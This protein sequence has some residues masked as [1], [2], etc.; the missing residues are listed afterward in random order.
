MVKCQACGLENEDSAKDCARCGYS[1]R[2][3]DPA[4]TF[5]QPAADELEAILD[6]LDLPALEH[7]VPPAAGSGQERRPPP[8][9]ESEKVRP[10]RAAQAVQV[11]RVLILIVGFGALFGPWGHENNWVQSGWAFAIYLTLYTLGLFGL[12]YLGLPLYAWSVLKG[13]R[14]GWVFGL[15]GVVLVLWL[16]WG[17]M[18]ILD[19]NIGDWLLEITWGAKLFLVALIL[20]NFFEGLSLARWGRQTSKRLWMILGVVWM[21]FSL[22]FLPLRNSVSAKPGRRL[23]LSEEE[24]LAR[25]QVGRRDFRR[26]DLPEPQLAEKELPEINLGHAQLGR[27]NMQNANLRGANLPHAYM[28]GARLAGADLHLANL[29]HAH[30]SHADLR[31]ANLTEAGLSAAHLGHANFGSAN[32]SRANLTEAELLWADLSGADLTGADLTGAN[33]ENASLEGVKLDA[34]AKIAPKWRLVWEIVNEG[35]ATRDLAG[36]DLRDAFLEEADL[37]EADLRGADLVWAKLYGADLSGAD[38]RDATMTNIRLTG[39]DLTGAML[40][41]S[42]L[43]DADLEGANLTEADLSRAN[44]S[45]ANLEEANLTQVNLSGANLIGAAVTERQLALAQSL[46]GTILPDGTVHE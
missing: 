9:E 3:E 25:Y 30:L 14:P 29:D 32:L 43:G 39:A 31:G 18:W 11:V 42:N 15:S 7:P 22:V 38:L 12:P 2:P 26:L 28:Y 13:G 36:V 41:D 24:L 37:S 6:Q 20:A 19:S 34:S 8:Q 33:L 10:S 21:V 27:A 45:G 44:M 23:E 35:G 46:Q 1:L 40:A 17:A 5:A 4:H 16:P